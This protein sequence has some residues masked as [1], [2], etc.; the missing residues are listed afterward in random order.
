MLVF[1]REHVKIVR[2]S[3]GNA[4]GAHALPPPSISSHPCSPPSTLL[5]LSGDA[6]IS[7]LVLCDP[8]H[9]LYCSFTASHRLVLLVLVEV[10]SDSSLTS[11]KRPPSPPLP[12]PPSSLLLLSLPSSC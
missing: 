7:Q 6:V 8:H 12:P 3:L 2:Y 1:M 10:L 4:V 11:S 5:L 9:L